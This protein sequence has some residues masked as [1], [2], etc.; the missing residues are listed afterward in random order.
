[1]G[2]HH[3]ND[4]HHTVPRD[5]DRHAGY[6]CHRLMVMMVICD[7]EDGGRSAGEVCHAGD[8][9]NACH[10]RHAGWCHYAKIIVIRVLP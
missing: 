3:A 10:D 1:M 5:D 9:L 4:G 2:N 7:P 8:V 6:G